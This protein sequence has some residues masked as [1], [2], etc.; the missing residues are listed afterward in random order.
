VEQPDINSYAQVGIAW[1]A[2]ARF[3]IAFNQIRNT[4]FGSGSPD[5]L[6]TGKLL[7]NHDHG[8]L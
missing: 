3:D 5:S 4:L 6:D 8:E 1:F 7:R 2:G